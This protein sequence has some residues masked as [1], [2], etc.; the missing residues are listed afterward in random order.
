MRGSFL[1]ESL[2]VFA[3]LVIMSG[4][5]LAISR[6][7]VVMALHSSGKNVMVFVHI[8]IYYN[9]VMLYFNSTYQVRR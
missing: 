9:S 2:A 5:T 7:T 6:S 3:R 4:N 8:I 1:A